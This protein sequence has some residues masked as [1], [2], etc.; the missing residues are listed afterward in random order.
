MWTKIPAYSYS[1]FFIKDRIDKKEV[2]VEYCPTHL[3]LADYFTKSLRGKQ[4]Q[5]QSEYIMGWKPISDLLND[6]RNH[7]IKEG[8]EI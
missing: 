6:I 7:K 2:K 5:R 1:L 8:V 4:F 3:M